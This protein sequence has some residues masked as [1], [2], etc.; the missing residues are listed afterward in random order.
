[1]MLQT[2]NTTPQNSMQLTP[3]LMDDSSSEE[4]P[5]PTLTTTEKEHRG[6]IPGSNEATSMALAGQQAVANPGVERSKPQKVKKT[7]PTVSKG[8]AAMQT[9][10]QQT[11][12][13]Q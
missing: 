4:E 12:K 10:S 7:T 6:T 8:H 3:T 5:D 13:K 1:M 11:T 9:E 2:R